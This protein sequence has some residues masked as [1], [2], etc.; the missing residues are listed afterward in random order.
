[1]AHQ[2]IAAHQLKTALFLA[3]LTGL[4]LMA[5]RSLAGVA[6]I[7]VAFIVAIVIN[8][9]AYWF[10]APF[11]CKLFHAKPII[12]DD[13][14]LLHG[15][16]AYLAEKADLPTPRMYRIDHK[17]PNAFTIGRNP[18][19]AA[20]V[21]TS[22]LLKILSKDELA[23]VM[24][25]EIAHIVHRDTL[26]ATLAA[27]IGGML[28]T[29]AN[30]VQVVVYLGARRPDTQPNWIGKLIMG[31]LAPVMALL[32]QLTLARSREFDADAKAAE[33]CGNAMWLANALYKIEQAKERYELPIAEQHPATAL[34]FAINPLHNRQWSMMFSTHPPVRDRI[35][36][37]EILA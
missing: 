8:L 28:S 27:G 33:L 20:I 14:P 4:L 10:S 6:G 21:V 15:T 11:L 23:G 37:L 32:I 2:D 34:L 31:M 26:L 35:N 19:T 7:Q 17:F 5:G 29:L 36:R 18:E 22:G 1:M 25:H 12:T 13:E 24:A 9:G 30:M 16:V 3:A